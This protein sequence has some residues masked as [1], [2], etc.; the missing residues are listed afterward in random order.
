MK[1]ITGEFS[2]FNPR[3][4]RGEPPHSNRRTFAVFGM[5][6]GDLLIQ[7]VGHES[8][9]LVL[10]RDQAEELFKVIGEYLAG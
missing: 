7:S 9:F 6:S 3:P 2:C 5:P 8:T 10:E 1:P 4:S